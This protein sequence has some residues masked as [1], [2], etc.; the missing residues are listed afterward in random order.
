MAWMAQRTEGVGTTFRTPFGCR[1]EVYAAADTTVY[2]TGAVVDGEMAD[3]NDDG[4]PDLVTL[5]STANCC[6]PIPCAC[7][8]LAVTLLDVDPTGAAPVMHP[9]MVTLFN[10]GVRAMATGDVDQDTTTDV[11]LSA[12]ASVFWLPNN[13]TGGLFPRTLLASLSSDV[14]S[15]L[16]VADFGGDGVLDVVGISLF[17]TP[18]RIFW[19]N[20]TSPL[21]WASPTPV[22]TRTGGNTGGGDSDV[23]AIDMDKDGLVDLVTAYPVQVHLSSSSSSSFVS[24]PSPDKVVSGGLASL[25]AGDVDQDG[26]TDV[27]VTDTAVVALYLNSGN[28]SLG[29]RIV[30]N[31]DTFFKYPHFLDITGDNLPDLVYLDFPSIVVRA[32]LGGGDFDGP[33]E[34]FGTSQSTLFVLGALP[35][36]LGTPPALIL[37]NPQGS[38][39]G[40]LEL[41][42]PLAPVAVELAPVRFTSIS[43]ARIQALAAGDIDSDGK[44]DVVA[45]HPS[46]VLVQWYPNIGTTSFA[47]G[48][49]RPVSTTLFG[50]IS[51]WVVDGNNDGAPDVFIFSGSA[52]SS[53]A[54]FVNLDG[55]GSFGPPVN[56]LPTSVGFFLALTDA[57]DDGFPDIVATSFFDRNNL[58]VLAGPA[59]DPG[60]LVYVFGVNPGFVVSEVM[61]ADLDGDHDTDLVVTFS[62]GTTT[63]IVWYRNLGSGQSW[64]YNGLR[65]LVSVSTI[66]GVGDVDG[67]GLVDIV[68]ATDG[69]IR[70][71]YNSPS[72]T[73]YWASADVG[74]FE[75]TSVRAKTLGDVNGDHILDIIVV[76]NQPSS[77]FV[78]LYGVGD[79]SFLPP[80]LVLDG[81]S[82]NFVE[83]AVLVYDMD[84]D[85][86]TDFLHYLPT[87]DDHDLSDPYVRFTQTL[88]R[89]AYQTLNPPSPP[90]DLEVFTH[91]GTGPCAASRFT[92]NCVLAAARSRSHCT[93]ETVLLPPGT[94]RGCHALR[95]PTLFFPV[96][97]AAA[98]PGSVVFDCEETGVLLRL[99][100]FLTLGGSDKGGEISFSG[101][102][103]TRMG[104]A[105]NSDTPAPGLRV[106]GSGLALV[107]RNVHITDAIVDADASERA[108]DPGGAILATD[109]AR[110]V[111]TDT[112]F[113]RCSSSAPGGAL[114]LRGST[115]LASLT[116]VSFTD[117]RT[118]SDGGAI[119]LSLGA[120]L[121]TTAVSFV[122]NSAVGSGGAVAVDASSSA[123]FTF[124]EF[125][126]NTATGLGGAIVVR[127][128][129]EDVVAADVT[130]EDV[131]LNSNT[132]HAGG[133]LALVAGSLDAAIIATGSVM[134]MPNSFD[135]NPNQTSSLLLGPRVSFVNNTALTYGGGILLCS[136]HQS[137]EGAVDAGSIWSG[138]VAETSPIAQSSADMFV[139]DP[140]IGR[141]EASVGLAV[142]G[143]PSTIDWSLDKATAATTTTSVVSGASLSGTFSLRDAFGSTVAY[144]T[145]LVTLEM[146]TVSSNRLVTNLPVSTVANTPVVPLPTSEFAV[147]RA[148]SSSPS[149]PVPVTVELR[150][151]DLVSGPVA[152]TVVPC[153]PGSGS[154]NTSS[155]DG[156]EVWACVEC[157]PGFFADDTSF[158]PCAVI[159]SCPV[160]A[161][162]EGRINNG[163]Q[164]ACVCDAGF[165]DTTRG[166]GE[167]PSCIP[168][169]TGA[170]CLR[171][172][173]EPQPASGFFASSEGTFVACLR[174]KACPG[175]TDAA[176]AP[177]Y[178]GYMCN[179]CASGFYSDATGVCRA[180]PPAADGALV[181]GILLTLVLACIA[182]AVV[183][184]TLMGGGR[185]SNGAGSEDEEEGARSEKKKG[186][187]GVRVRSTPST[188]SMVITVAQVIG[189]LGN[190]QLGW[191]SRSQSALAFFNA[192]SVDTSWFA[193]ECSLSSFH[194]KYVLSVAL[195]LVLLGAVFGVV[196]AA[197]ALGA[198]GVVSG[199]SA[200]ADVS[201][202]RAFDTVVFTIA[203]LLYIPMARATLIIF[204]CTRLP[205]GTFVLDANPGVAC[206]D[207]SWLAV[208]WV[209]VAGV[210][211]YVVGLP[212]Y[213]SYC[214]WPVRNALLEKDTFAKYG[215]IYKLFRVPFWWCGVA[216]L[217]RRLA[218][219][220]VALFVST[221][222]TLQIGLFMALFLPSLAFLLARRPY[223]Y[224]LYNSVD[225][226]L[227]FLLFVILVLG[228]VSHGERGRDSSVSDV[229]FVLLVID[230]V[231]LGVVAIGAVFLDTR[232]IWRARSDAYDPWDD[233]GSRVV[234]NLKLELVDLDPTN[235]TSLVHFILQHQQQ[236]HP[237]QQ[238]QQQ[239][240]QQHM[241]LV[242]LSLGS[243]GSD[244]SS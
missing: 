82:G 30:L 240:Q 227:S 211:I 137:L 10:E 63:S 171:G 52:A 71:F 46:R 16:V 18:A 203:P 233:R 61:S 199:L 111:A 92:L 130:M 72:A 4:V 78:V 102:N 235:R 229:V 133:A 131:L 48:E 186:V 8:A 166:Q 135:P 28:G 221:H 200:L 172:R 189:I 225:A 22:I 198:L 125:E 151:G 14:Y 41:Y 107:L 206:G 164:P 219:V 126:R 196:V 209:G 197:R 108:V 104:L 76:Y 114:A 144:T 60:S 232:Q 50:P 223:F 118:E 231:L 121:H 165:M 116:N 156:S 241:E 5:H 56:V 103:I 242:P 31:V 237:E 67:D 134:D 70:A 7:S 40:T 54:M 34:L 158:E 187:K 59:Y 239:Q 180:C 99:G 149:D 218:I 143:A 170:V 83:Q 146:A 110:L 26:Y 191:S 12:W 148:S 215:A 162:E 79:G 138:N 194:I 49:P 129:G 120:R 168:C 142:S 236:Q 58:Y 192:A 222:V 204:D 224:P 39:S 163:S 123:S 15:P 42:S 85:G 150:L 38:Y 73:N 11:V 20:S 74:V 152:I 140:G 109:G 64:F 205:N 81:A 127:P 35:A 132:A 25:A 160:H 53:L 69:A 216:E 179:T 173:A 182:G 17:S 208:V 181:G 139:C 153:G 136:S 75:T 238:Q 220:G 13:G 29:E 154:V 87:I 124:A 65:D 185:P 157:E 55:A 213:L 167:Q 66:I 90:L 159:V 243:S 89:S 177:G 184:F 112:T 230:L 84:S 44:V 217:C 32:N 117:C 176:C 91:D 77:G 94:Y 33:L 193:S 98:S 9:P 201:L 106:E 175:R 147:V 169:P 183:I 113:T 24:L 37:S 244:S 80:Q 57:N 36:P 188:A 155:A 97:L 27:L 228:S 1:S 45:I 6:D 115:V 128:A 207:D 161:V 190:A 21:S 226:A 212:A 101:V 234:R 122:A 47:A 202:K 178:T 100:D 141:L 105:T 3:M 214:V 51:A 174:P 96:T 68:A 2:A 86:D 43:A 95:H 195:P 145:A 62:A 210:W 88:S 23:L 119:K 19:I 93:P